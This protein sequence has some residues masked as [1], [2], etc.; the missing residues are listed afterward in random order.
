M[1]E[2]AMEIKLEDKKFTAALKGIDLESGVSSEFDDI[3]RRAEAKAAGLD[4]E[5]YE[6]NG[7]FDIID[8]DEGEIE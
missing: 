6:L 7:L 8:E 2:T 4:E 3:K 1:Y 5:E